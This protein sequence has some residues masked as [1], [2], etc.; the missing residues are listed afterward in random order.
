MGLYLFIALGFNINSATGEAIRSVEPSQG[1][2]LLRIYGN[3][4]ST[5]TARCFAGFNHKPLIDRDVKPVAEPLDRVPLEYHDKSCKK[6][7]D[8]EGDGV[9]EKI[10]SPSW[11]S[12]MVIVPKPNGDIRL[13]L[14]SRNINKAIVRD[15]YQLPTIEELSKLFSGAKKFSKLDLKAGYWQ[16]DFDPS[17]R[18]ITAMITRK[19]LY[20]WKGS[21]SGCVHHL[22]LPED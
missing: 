12:N 14:N 10:D 9:L 5:D 13:C 20:Q 7:D 11:V 17:V 3:L 6:L 8:M 21:L 1:H 16:I 18:Y 22:L 2:P 15:R 19:G 4:L